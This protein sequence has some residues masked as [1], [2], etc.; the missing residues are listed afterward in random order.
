MFGNRVGLVFNDSYNIESY[1]GSSLNTP[2][3][4]AVISDS[5]GN[6]LF[7]TNGEHIWDRRHQPMPN[8]QNLSNYLYIPTQSTLIVPRPGTDN[9]YYLFITDEPDRPG[10]SRGF[11]Y[12][13]INMS[14]NN[15]YGDVV[16]GNKNIQLLPQT[17]E[18]ITAVEHANGLEYWVIT[19]GWDNNSFHVFHI[20]NQ[21]PDPNDSRTFSLGAIHT[22]GGDPNVWNSKGYLKVSPRGDKIASII[23]EDGIVDFFDFDNQTGVISNHAMLPE[24]YYRAYGLEFSPDSRFIYFTSLKTTIDVEPSGLFQVDLA[25]LDVTLIA[26][27]SHPAST[28]SALQVGMDSRIY[29]SRINKSGGQTFHTSIGVIENPKRLGTDCNFVETIPGFENQLFQSGFPNFVQ[30]YFDIPHFV[31]YPHCDGDLVELRLWNSLNTSATMWDFDDGTTETISQ[32]FIEHTFPNAGDFNVS[33]TETYGTDQFGPFSENI[34]IQALPTLM[35]DYPDDIL[36]LF[37]G[38]AYPMD[39]GGPFYEYRWYYSANDT[40]NW[41]EVNGGFGEQFREYSILEEGFY[42]LEVEDLECCFNY[43]IIEVVSLDVE[44]P[45]AFIPSGNPPNNI[46]KVNGGSVQNFSML[47]YNRWGQ[48]VFSEELSLGIGNGWNGR[49]QN[50]GPECP[51]GVYAYILLFDVEHE[52]DL[53]TITRSGSVMLLR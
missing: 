6:L 5:D 48:M 43:R 33:V 47:V 46:F 1:S 23:H 3:G 26:N 41:T 31:H 22:S 37:P 9:Q 24:T 19:H 36:F 12:C 15:G 14:L 28:F 16:D 21:L 17:A 10:G 38:A 42:K 20:T 30:S 44:I 29:V 11:R 27:P 4:S 39:G 51:M 49:M 7:Y 18:K 53:K 35:P 40:V 52:G 25:S 45:T 2:S 8:G 50:S 13:L 34:T 32:S